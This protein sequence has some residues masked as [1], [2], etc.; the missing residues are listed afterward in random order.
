MVVSTEAFVTPHAPSPD[1]S[2]KR[3]RRCLDGCPENETHRCLEISVVCY[4]GLRYQGACNSSFMTRY[5]MQ[6]FRQ[7][8][9][10][11]LIPSAG[12]LSGTGSTG[13]DATGVID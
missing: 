4:L 2:L 11:D 1:L 10:C 13:E 3:Q 8:K 6:S 5:R 7:P 12:Y 9:G